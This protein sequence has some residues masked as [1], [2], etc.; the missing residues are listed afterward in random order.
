LHAEDVEAWGF[1]GGLIANMAAF[2]IK[3]RVD[4]VFDR[5]HVHHSDIG[6]RLR[7]RGDGG[8]RVTIRDSLVHHA[9]TAIRYE[10]DI[11]TILVERLTIGLDVAR[12]FRGVASSLSRPDVRD[13]LLLGTGLPPEARGRGRVVGPQFFVDV[14]ANDYRPRPEHPLK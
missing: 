10:D 8:A 11:S 7:G 6:F 14:A 2:N 9:A 13:L 3:E 1:R 12:P 4:A 5:V